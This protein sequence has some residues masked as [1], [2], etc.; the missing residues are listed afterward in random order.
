M[1][2]LTIRRQ[3]GT[4]YWVEH[5]NDLASA[6]KWIAEEQ[7]RPYWNNS[8]TYQIVDRTPPPKTPE[9]IAAEETKRLQIVALRQRIRA[10]ADQSDLTAA[11]V[12]EAIFKFI[13]MKVL[14]GEF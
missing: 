9:E 12:K 10:L 2:E 1:F 6:Q 11:E 14:Q 8:Y 7:T 4:V 13:K 5:F 3:D